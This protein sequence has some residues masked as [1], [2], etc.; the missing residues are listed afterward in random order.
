MPATRL[1]ARSAPSR[2]SSAS[3]LRAAS[4]KRLYCAGSSG[5]LSNFP[6]VIDGVSFVSS[7]GQSAF[8]DQGIVVQRKG[9]S[10]VF[11]PLEVEIG[12]T[13]IQIQDAAQIGFCGRLLDAIAKA[14][15]KFLSRA[16]P[17]LAFF[18]LLASF[19]SEILR[20]VK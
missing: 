8:A 7:G 11:S 10:L 3:A 16:D 1:K 17:L 19:A 9:H 18:R 4:K 2:V 20:V 13:T 12:T 14:G 15:Q 6:R 5:F